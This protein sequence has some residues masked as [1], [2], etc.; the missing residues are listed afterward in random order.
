MT[1]VVCKLLVNSRSHFTWSK[2]LVDFMSILNTWKWTWFWYFQN[3]FWHPSQISTNICKI[4]T[5]TQNSPTISLLR[6]NYSQI[7]LLFIQE[8]ICKSSNFDTI[9]WVQSMLAICLITTILM[10]I[11]LLIDPAI[12]S[13]T[14]IHCLM[15][16]P[17]SSVFGG[18]SWKVQ[19]LW[20]ACQAPVGQPL[21]Y[22]EEQ[23][24]LPW[25]WESSSSKKRVFIC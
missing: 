9:F 5:K 3:D 21:C 25:T 14:T 11:C 19:G 2:S 12:C 1:D 4:S 15:I 7:L 16:T 23:Y 6:D 10:M 13:I 18:V 22:Q 17:C 24:P 8:L 20:T